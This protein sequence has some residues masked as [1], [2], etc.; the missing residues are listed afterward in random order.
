MLEQQNFSQSSPEQYN[1]RV[2]LCENCKTAN[3]EIAKFCKECGRSI[4]NTIRR[5]EQ[6]TQNKF[7]NDLSRIVGL[8]NIK[9]ILTQTINRA[10]IYKQRKSKGLSVEPL[11]LHFVFKGN[12]GTGKTMIARYLSQ[13]FKKEGVL[14]SGSFTEIDYEMMKM[15]SHNLTAAIKKWIDKAKG[16]ILFFDEIHKNPEFLPT[17]IR[18][19]PL[20]GDDIVV[21]IAGLKDPLDKYFE[22]NPE[23]K[24]RI[25]IFLDFY[26]YT[27]EELYQITKFKLESYGFQLDKDAVEK[28]KDYVRYITYAGKSEFK[29]GWLVERKI[30]PEIQ[31][32]QS[33]RLIKSSNNSTEDL[34]TITSMDIPD[35]GKPKKPEE[36]I[37]SMDKLVGMENI[38]KEIKLLAQ[39]INLQQEQRKSGMKVET[40]G[41]HIVLTGN[42]GTGK[43]TVAR[44]LGELFKAIGYLPS[45][46]CVEVDRSKLVGQYVGHTAPNVQKYCDEAMGGILFIDEAYTLAGEEGIKDS[47]GQEAIDTLLKRMEDDRGKFVVIVA[48]YKEEMER[49]I[50][51]NPGLK[52]RFTHFFHLDDYKP[53]ELVKIFLIMANNAGYI[54]SDAA[55]EKLNVV[56]KEMYERRTKKFSN[57]REV[58][59]LFEGT[60]RQLS[61]RLADIPAE[62]RTSES[63]RTILPEDIP[64]KI[65][66]PVSVEEIMAELDNLIG[67]DNIKK[68]I[69]SLVSVINV[70][71]KREKLEGK[72]VNIAPHMV[73]LGNP[74]TG[75]TTVARILGR[76]Y[77]SIGILPSDHV[78]EVDKAGLVGQYVGQTP[79]KVNSV[80]DRAMGGILF[81]DEAYTLTPEGNI[82]S[83]AQ[84]A[85]DTLLKRMEDDKGKFVVIAAGYP[86]EMERFLKSNPGLPSR[87]TK[88]IIFEDYKPDE[89][90][91]IFK[92]IA[93][94]NQ[95]ELSEKATIALKEHCKFM[96][97]NKDENFGN[98]RAVRNLFEQVL[99]NQAMR[100]SQMMNEKMDIDNQLYFIIEAEDFPPLKRKEEITLEKVL[101]ELENL[102]GL[103]TVKQEIKQLI[104]FLNVEKLRNND[105][106]L[107]ARMTLHYVFTGNPGTGKTTVARILAKIF[108]ALG[109]LPKGHLVEKDRS[110]LVAE[111][112]GQTAVKTTAAINE[113]MGGVLFIDEAYA[114]IPESG[115]IDFGKEAVDTLLKRM[116][117]DKDK[118]IVIVAG[119][120][121]EMER[122]INSNPGLSSRFTRKLHF[123]DYT[124]D[125]LYEIFE[126]MAKSRKMIMSEGFSAK[127][128]ERLKSIYE[129]RDRN[130]ANGRTVRNLFESTLRLQASR[131][132]KIPNIK[133]DS[134]ILYTFE[135][136]DLV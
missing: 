106:P 35:D 34:I 103:L 62:R 27:P 36:V 16:G 6:V 58:R 81:I 116:E 89:L 98:G 133:P 57:G 52:S 50:N 28:L 73:F 63:I 41:I 120:D 132:A 5:T 130:F 14:S 71:R 76:L 118:F 86:K 10:K 84:E 48:G 94:N 95:Y 83:F 97:E 124:P 129:K 96:Y 12:T 105:A 136:G 108:K 114:L 123:D 60:I 42:P 46:H 69:R 67:M 93:K 3:R 56:F 131:V 47:F 111:Y 78:V 68:E 45:G 110:G 11:Y 4:Q 85:V 115:G 79:Q 29:N 39:T 54:V 43:T 23:D 64:Y 127:L 51:S 134:P 119:Y 13:E 44:L 65:K 74:G 128:R 15:E 24:Q 18:S 40:I 55:I 31:T 99:Q 112:V 82:D 109:I 66:K 102:T 80:I 92:T 77:N 38:K 135:E 75:K 37:A 8:D 117:D 30:I 125:E 17:I 101:E 107:L 33:N 22:E 100:L 91:S 90:E 70:Q 113:A 2:I 104:D 20:C 126:K 121:K 21:I 19:L 87:F 61:A 49:F 25:G 1:K 7:E 53:E 26:D 72:K 88:K 9:R 122:F 59:N 32:L